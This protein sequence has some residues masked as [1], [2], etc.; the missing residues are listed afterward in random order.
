MVQLMAGEASFQS[1][2]QHQ[3]Q[4]LMQGVVHIDRSGVV[5]GSVVAPVVSQQPNIK[6]PA[7][8]FFLAMIH[9]FQRFRPECDRRKSRRAAQTFLRSAVSGIDLQSIDFY[10]NSGE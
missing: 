9:R 7:G 2:F 6:V 4:S 1:F 3:S 8:D 10:R 5:I